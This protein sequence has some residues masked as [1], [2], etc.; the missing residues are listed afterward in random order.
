MKI[1]A[2]VDVHNKLNALK[3]I[4]EKAKKEKPDLL[5]CAGDISI[6]ENGL[7][8]MISEVNGLG[9][10][11]LFVHGNHETQTRIAKAC[12]LFKNTIYVHDKVFIKEN[13]GFFGY[14][15]GG[16]SVVDEGFMKSVKRHTAGLNKT[17]KII[18][19]THAPPYGSRVDKLH[20]DY[21]GNKSITRFIKEYNPKLAIC[22][23]L[24]ENKGKEDF[25]GKTKVVNPGPEGKIIN[26]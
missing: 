17:K 5:I 9:I 11:A 14:G 13:F 4:K 25:I 23:H 16:F 2:F 19:I 6:F 26:I 21:C 1:L 12:S 8:Y 24:H 15:G 3:K 20:G 18:L 10:P 22:G 7:E